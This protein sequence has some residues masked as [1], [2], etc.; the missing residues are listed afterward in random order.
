MLTSKQELLLE[1]INKI[2]NPEIQ[3]E[4]LTKLKRQAK[5]KIF[6]RKTYSTG[7]V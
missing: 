6:N 2:D 1:V 7:N 3:K 5:P 4:Y